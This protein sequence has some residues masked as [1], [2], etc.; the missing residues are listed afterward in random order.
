MYATPIYVDKL[1]R[2]HIYYIFIAYLINADKPN[3]TNRQLIQNPHFTVYF[4]YID[5]FCK[6][7]TII[8][9]ITHNDRSAR[10]RTRSHFSIYYFCIY[11]H[12]F[13]QVIVVNFMLSLAL[14]LCIHFIPQESNLLFVNYKFTRI[15]ATNSC[16]RRKNYS[17]L[18]F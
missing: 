2:L 12:F 13:V 14:V 17:C 1:D 5:L 6:T 9:T 15:Q 11:I 18:S 10:S 3:Q 4:Y 7:T 16:S 8:I